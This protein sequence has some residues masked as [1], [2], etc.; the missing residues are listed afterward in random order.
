MKSLW[1][2]TSRNKKSCS[3][4]FQWMYLT[5]PSESIQDRKSVTLKLQS[6]IF[7]LKNFTSF[8]AT[9][10]RIFTRESRDLIK[11]SNSRASKRES[12]QGWLKSQNHGYHSGKPEHIGKTVFEYKNCVNIICVHKHII[13]IA[14]SSV[15]KI[16]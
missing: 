6:W 7:I 11:R 13:I 2:F 10:F 3:T 9:E 4:R 14:P 8:D 12:N 5:F 15:H 16:K 1:T